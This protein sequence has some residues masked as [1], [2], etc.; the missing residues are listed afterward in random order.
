MNID[1]RIFLK[2]KFREYYCKNRIPAPNEIERREFGVGTLESKIKIRHKSF[3]TERELNNFLRRDSPFY[4]SYSIA[5]YEFPE[6]QPMSNKGWLGSDLVFDLDIDMDFINLERLESVKEN[7][8]NLIEFLTSDFGFSINEIGIN[9]SGTKGYHIHV[10]NASVRNLESDERR[11]IIDYITGSGLKIECFMY[12]EIAKGVTDNYRMPSII[13]GPRSD[14]LG[15]ARRIYNAAMEFIGLEERE[16]RRINGIGETKAKRIAKDRNTIIRL[17][18]NGRWDG[19]VNLNFSRI[20]QERVIRENAIRLTG[21]ADRMVTI[22]KTRLIRLPET[23]HAGSGLIAKKISAKELTEFNPLTDAIAF[24]EQ[25]IGI[26]IKSE[27]PRF[28]M[29]E[30][31]FGPYKKGIVKVPEYVGIYLMLNDYAEYPNKK[32]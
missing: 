6:N 25:L 17:L 23:L 14:S 4:I 15:W 10:N 30:Q 12:P 29:N 3:K 11:E 27:I 2:K 7:A 21:H 28:E 9:F 20:I 1:T 24:S 26:R 5:Y 13:R 16:L 22:D 32:I 19:V 31:R 18:E 8:I